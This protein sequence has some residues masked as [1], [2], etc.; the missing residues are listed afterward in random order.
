MKAQH[1]FP[2]LR[3]QDTEAAQMSPPPIIPLCPVWYL[4]SLPPTLDETCGV[5]GSGSLWG[6]AWGEM[7]VGDW[8][9]EDPLLVLIAIT[10]EERGPNH[11]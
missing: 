6:F 1:H 7:W 3:A 11:R 2:H 4:I 5:S 9:G 10:L 8:G